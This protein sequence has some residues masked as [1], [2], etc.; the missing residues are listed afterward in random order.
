MHYIYIL[1]SKKLNKYYI[2]STAAVEARLNQ[3]N[4]GEV[5]F[6]SRGI[7]WILKYQEEFA[8]RTSA[9][10]REYQI[11]SKKSRKY[12]EWVIAGKNS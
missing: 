3:H 1:Y 12:I 4:N 8:D 9:M 5:K 10:K 2:G 11:K 7:P 6:T